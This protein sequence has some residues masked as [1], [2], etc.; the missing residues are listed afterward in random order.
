MHF[1]IKQTAYNLGFTYCGIAKAVPL[2]E[3]ARRLEKWLTQHHHGSMQYMENHFDLRID[4]T[5]LVPGA[6]SVITVLKNYYPSAEQSSDA[7][8]IDRKSV[9]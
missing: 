1:S 7:P 2:N 6:K 9:V 3:D 8:R 5:K 4:P